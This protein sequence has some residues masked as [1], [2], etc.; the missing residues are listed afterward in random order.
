MTNSQKY[1]CRDYARNSNFSAKEIADIVGC[2]VG[3]ARDYIKIFRKTAEQ[4]DK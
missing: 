1:L 2:C 3:T 4:K